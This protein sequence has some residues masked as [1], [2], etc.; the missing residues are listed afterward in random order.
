MAAVTYSHR[1]DLF[2]KLL[3]LGL[4]FTVLVYTGDF[5]MSFRKE[6]APY[7]IVGNGVDGMAFLA[8]FLMVGLAIYL[9]RRTPLHLVPHYFYVRWSLRTPLQ[10]NEM[11]QV[12]FLFQPSADDG[13]WYPLHEIRRLPLEQRRDALFSAAAQRQ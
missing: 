13:Q 9:A 10:W 2:F 6:M 1:Y 8:T 12:A 5:V 3:F 11:P 4:L 7:G